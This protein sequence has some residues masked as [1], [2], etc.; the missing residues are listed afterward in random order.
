MVEHRHLAEQIARGHQPDHR[1][2][3]VDRVG[4]R[5]RD[6]TGQHDVEGIGLVALVEQDVA[7]H[8]LS[9]GGCL[10]HA[11]QFLTTR[12]GKEF[13]LGKDVVMSHGRP[14]GTTVDA[15]TRHPVQK[16]WTIVVA[17]G[18][19][20]RFGRPKQYEPIGTAR[21]VDISM[22]V[23]RSVSDGVVLVV[24]AHD[25][26]GE[27]G[28]AGGATRSESVRNGLAAVPADASIICV[29]DAAR[30]FASVELYDAVIAAVVAGADCA[31]P[32]IVVTDTIKI[33]D[34]DGVVV[35][36]PE[37]AALRAVQTPQAFRADALREAHADGAEGTDDAALVEARGGRVVVV[38]GSE[39]NRKI[40]YPADLAWAQARMTAASGGGR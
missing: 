17:G 28:V 34:A 25:V 32:G 13:G 15:M 33:V 11:E 5:D 7:A 24:P 18:G 2:A 10:E 9:L 37:R 30:P 35:A 8:Q 1:L 29:H 22:A 19:S 20:Q 4:D 3:V 6:A 36:T 12:V 31:I 27:G 26:A 39:D 21:V 14:D 40:T 23:A 38:P 16:V